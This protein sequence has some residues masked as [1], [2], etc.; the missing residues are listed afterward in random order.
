[1]IQIPA[2]IQSRHKALLFEKA[3]PE[4]YHLY[5]E[6]GATRSGENV[7]LKNKIAIIST[8]KEGLKQKKANWKPV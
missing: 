2:Q 4:I 8:T 6:I 3:I 1:M 7:T 5:Y